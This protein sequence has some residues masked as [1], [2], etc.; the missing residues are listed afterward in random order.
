MITLVFLFNRI[1]TLFLEINVALNLTG[2]SQI[3][4]NKVKYIANAFMILS[5]V[6]LMVI[7][8]QY[9]LMVRPEVSVYITLLLGGK[10]FTMGTALSTLAN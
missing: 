3:L 5:L 9:W 6:V 4:Q 2:Y 7:M 8:Q 10:T 1:I